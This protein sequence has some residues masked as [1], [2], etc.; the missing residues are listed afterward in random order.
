MGVEPV[1][2]TGRDSAEGGRW[3]CI[4]HRDPFL[5]CEFVVSVG[6]DAKVAAE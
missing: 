5:E 2:G 4:N 6:G 3:W 1:I